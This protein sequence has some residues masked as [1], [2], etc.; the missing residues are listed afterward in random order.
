MMNND[1]KELILRDTYQ[2]LCYYQTLLPNN[3]QHTALVGSNDLII[4]SELEKL[5]YSTLPSVLSVVQQRNHKK[6]HI[7]NAQSQPQP[8]TS[9]A[10]SD[11]KEYEDDDSIDILA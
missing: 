7:V 2:K 11:A 8:E 5:P 3:A 4:V 1:V 6:E 10:D 9:S